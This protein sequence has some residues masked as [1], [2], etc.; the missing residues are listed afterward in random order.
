M[1]F[2]SLVLP[3]IDRRRLA[4]NILLHPRP[5]PRPLPTPTHTHAHTPLT[6]LN[7][8]SPSTPPSPPALCCALASLAPTRRLHRSSARQFPGRPP[9]RPCDRQ[10]ARS[11]PR[12]SLPLESVTTTTTLTYTPSLPAWTHARSLLLVASPLPTPPLPSV[13]A[14][15]PR[16]RQPT[17][18]KR[19]STPALFTQPRACCCHPP[20]CY[21]N[22]HTP[23][24]RA[25]GLP[26][27]PT[28]PLVANFFSRPLS[29]HCR[30]PANR[31]PT[32]ALPRS[33]PTDACVTTAQSQ[34]ESRRLLPLNHSQTTPAVSSARAPCHI[35]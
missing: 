6:P 2:R 25:L 24:P 5:L 30:R 14:A 21:A 4:A 1:L 8:A 10:P 23:V 16:P 32:P 28:R 11:L 18:H 3:P 13:V 27:A 7:L 17:S 12:A 9:D 22:T 29:H 31:Q 26:S 33:N 19:T 15:S 20:S 34:A 35:F